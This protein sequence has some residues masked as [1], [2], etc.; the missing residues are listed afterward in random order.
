MNMLTVNGASGK[1]SVLL[2]SSLEKVDQLSD[3]RRMVILTDENVFRYHG[4]NFPLASEVIVV[5]AGEQSKNLDHVARLYERLIDAEL[6]RTSLI[7]GIGGGV[8]TDLAG[9]VASTFL[10]GISFGFVAT[11]VLAQVDAAIGGK[12]GV[13]IKGYKNLVGVIRQPEFVIND[14]A[15]LRTLSKDQLINGMSEVIKSGLIA[16]APLF[17]LLEDHSS[18][19]ISIERSHI[20]EAISRAAQ[21]K[22]DIVNR[23]EFESGERRLLNLG[24][25]FG[26]AVEKIA[27]I[28]HGYAVAIGMVVAANIS[29]A[30]GMLSKSDGDRIERV[31][32]SFGLPVKI[33]I[34][35]D[36]AMDA[37]K[38]DKKRESESINFVLLDDIGSA[39]VVPIEFGE[40]REVIDDL[41]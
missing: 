29:V 40:L 8:V 17:D 13:N 16:D 5:P 15:V 2:D 32:S 41:R 9:F 24:H 7:V 3:G 12:N 23:D 26:H 38:K 35:I 30:K 6:D 39:K 31:I 4:A 14:T 10:R 1:S 19:M 36:D 33:D 11:T 27:K 18:E 25:T 34:N 28:P 37:M 20:G 22:V 21:V